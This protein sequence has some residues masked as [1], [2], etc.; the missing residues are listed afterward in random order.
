[1]NVIPQTR[2]VPSAIPGV[3]HTTWAGEA[4]GLRQL[5]VWRQTMAPGA[6]TP[7]HQH[8]SDELVLCL[9]GSGELRL[10]DQVQPFGADTTLVLP[11]GL[12]HQI[13]NTGTVP[14]ETIGIFGATPVGTFGTDGTPLALPW[15]S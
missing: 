1:M 12:P 5:S 15:R 6:A 13:V 10:G 7:P 3:A 4:D 8:D 9:A 2:P 11:R 14:M